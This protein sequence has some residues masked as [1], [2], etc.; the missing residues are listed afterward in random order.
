M[1]NAC[2]ALVHFFIRNDF[3][4]ERCAMSL[5]GD[6]DLLNALI[7]TS[8]NPDWAEQFQIETTVFSKRDASHKFMVVVGSGE[9]GKVD[10]DLVREAILNADVFIS[11]LDGYIT[12]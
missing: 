8:V 7:D 4:V 10:D 6:M 1:F 3:P 12:L 11:A 9:L 5:D 2:H